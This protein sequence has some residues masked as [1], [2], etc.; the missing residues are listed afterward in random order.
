MEINYIKENYKFLLVPLSKYNEYIKQ[1]KKLESEKDEKICS[2]VDSVVKNIYDIF[3]T[4]ITILYNHHKTLYE[5]TNI[6]DKIKTKTTPLSDI[7]KEGFL[8]YYDYTPKEYNNENV[9]DIVS[10]L[11][12]VSGNFLYKIGHPKIIEEVNAKES[13]ITSVKSNI[14]II[15]RFTNI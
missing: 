3:E 11:A 7:T 5:E 2:L 1:G 8:P 4:L 12:L 10:K 9:W 15:S 6:V 13:I 14:E